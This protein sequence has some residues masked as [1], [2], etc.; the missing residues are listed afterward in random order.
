MKLP[1]GYISLFDYCVKYKI[2]ICRMATLYSYGLVP[3]Q[4]L[5]T[6]DGRTGML[7]I[8]KNFP[9]PAYAASSRHTCEPVVGERDLDDTTAA[10][11]P[12]VK[13]ADEG[14]TVNDVCRALQLSKTTVYGW[15]RRLN[16]KTNRGAWKMTFGKAECQRLIDEITEARERKVSGLHPAPREVLIDGVKCVTVS[17]YAKKHNLLPS[18]MHYL[19]YAGYLPE[20]IRVQPEGNVRP[21][22]YI[23]K[24]VPP[25]VFR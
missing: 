18:R 3:M 6:S 7:I 15:L 13:A 11:E 19:R 20:A 14:Y 17:E 9:V 8:H 23:P 2:D 1:E 4:K 25:P 24:H 12:P 5:N 16:Y 22:L 21:T 10:K